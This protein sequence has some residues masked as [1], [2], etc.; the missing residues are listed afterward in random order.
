M[1]WVAGTKK[2]TK[3]NY[4]FSTVCYK[5]WKMA[6]SPP[7]LFDLRWGGIRRKCFLQKQ[8]K[9]LLKR[10]ESCFLIKIYSTHV[11]SVWWTQW[12][13]CRKGKNITRALMCCKWTGL[14]IST[15]YSDKYAKTC[16][17]T[18]RKHSCSICVT[19]SLVT[20]RVARNIYSDREERGREYA[21]VMGFLE[22]HG[23]NMG[24]LWVGCPGVY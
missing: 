21:M 22:G 1:D 10:M 6:S 4:G 9:I 14:F 5:G 12:P 16:W 18:S 8:F 2:K 17:Q 19:F 23:N 7:K 11:V 13:H 15:S 20:S 24:F 3:N